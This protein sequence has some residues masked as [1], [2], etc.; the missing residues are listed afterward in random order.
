MIKKIVSVLLI[1]SMIFLLGSCG[2]KEETT[3]TETEDYVLP[4]QVIDADISLPYISTD[5]FFPYSAKSSLNRDLIPLIYEG[6][7]VPTEDG[8]GM[9]Q[10]AVSG[11]NEG[12]KV[13]VKLLSNVK[14][15]DGVQLTS[16][17]VKA[18]YDKAKNNGYYNKSLKNIASIAT[19]DN[20][21]VV[22]TLYNPDALALNVLDF[23]IVRLSGK[24]Y[25]GTGKYSIGYLDEIPYL[26]VNTNH[27][28]YNKNWNK[29]VALYDMAGVSSPI[30][31][32]KANEISVYK[33]DL[34]DG[35]YNNLSSV[36]VS[37]KMNNLVFVGVNSTWA[38]SVTSLPWVRQAI[39][40]GVNR[41]GIVAASFL[42]Q[43]DP[44]VTPFKNSFYQLNTEN[45][46][47]TN[48]EMERAIAILERNGYT[49][50]NGDGVRTN[51]KN[52]LRVNILVCTQNQYK[53]T[54]AQALK[55]SLE[56]I[57]FGVTIT[58]KKTAKE[59]T[60]ALKT[61]HFGLY[62]GETQLTA[63]CDLSE[64]FTKDGTLSY[65][66]NDEFFAE[67]SAYKSGV[68]STTVFVEGFSTEVPF[69]PLFYRKTV[70]SV[71]PNI[72]GVSAGYNIY[73]DICNWKV[74]TNE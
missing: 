45:L 2:K 73:A 51:G 56:E 59:F 53:L 39:N 35:K 9:P 50:V 23:P 72:T 30:Y 33:D 74:S 41:S 36:T 6:L 5:S 29:Q 43:G 7:F 27:R 47:G 11:K 1:I 58:Q 42:G 46:P 31:P 64:F 48:G 25:V 24:K 61:G 55:S 65:G 63:N 66:V 68:D 8:K 67:Y 44:V 12:K 17:Y 40:I 13:T 10:L 26:Q 34:S 4:T 18:A 22:F 62:I 60:D 70:V 3:P 57:G 38:G 21:T 20:F 32:F 15:S 71:N 54:V 16:A 52:A 19:P 14:F 69:I 37:E 28:E 49:Q